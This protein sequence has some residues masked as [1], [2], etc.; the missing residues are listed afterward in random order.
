MNNPHD[1]IRNEADMLQGCTNRMIITHDPQELESMKEW[2]HKH[3][4]TIYDMKKEL[5]K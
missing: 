1:M 4:D 5:M 3:I 2:A